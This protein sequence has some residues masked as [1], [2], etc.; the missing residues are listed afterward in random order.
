MVL[1][2]LMVIWC[3]GSCYLTFRYGF[4]RRWA[5]TLDSF[6]LFLFGADLA[7]KVKDNPAFGKD[8][9]ECKELKTLPGLIGDSRP[10]F[11]PGYVTIVPSAE[12]RKGKYYL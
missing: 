7:D 5:G 8:A 2:M 12:A 1:A 4:S 6:S 10:Y 9:E 11:Q 3:L